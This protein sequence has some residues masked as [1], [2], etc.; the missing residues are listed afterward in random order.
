MFAQPLLD[1]APVADPRPVVARLT[2]DV[3]LVATPGF[4]SP[5]VPG[6][7]DGRPLRPPYGSVM[8]DGDSG[9]A[10][11]TAMRL[12][13]VTAALDDPI[14]LI[15]GLTQGSQR[16]LLDFLLGFCRTAFRIGA[17]P[18]FVTLCRR[19]TLLCM[20]DG[21]AAHPVARIGA[22][23]VVI[24]GM[25]APVDATLYL[26]GR[27]EVVH[28]AERGGCPQVFEPVEQEDLVLA[29]GADPAFW[30]IGPM[31]AFL[32]HALAHAGSDAE[33]RQA[34]LRAWPIGGD[35]DTRTGLVRELQLVMPAAARR[36][37]DPSQ[38]IGGALDL[39]V[40]DYDGRMFLRGWLRD[41]HDLIAG[42]ELETPSGRAPIPVA[43]FHRLRRAD[44]GAG[45]VALVDAPPYAQPTLR[46]LLRS[47]A[48][49]E[50]VPPPA[51]LAPAAARDAVLASVSEGD[52]T[53]D[54]LRRCVGPAAASL[55]RAAL[56]RLAAPDVITIGAKLRRPRI[57]LLIPLYRMLGFV[58]FQLGAF[59]SDPGFAEVE[60]IYTLD[61]PE[62]RA[63]VEHLLRGLYLL[64]ARSVTLVVMA[65]NAGFAAASN[66]AARVAR[67]PI[68]MLLN[69]DVV[70][71]APGWLEPLLA[72]LGRGCKR[73]AAPKLLFDDGS[74]QHAGLLFDRD[75]TGL[76]YNRHYH[77]GRPGDWPAANQAR[78]VPG[79]TGAALMIARAHFE[80]LGGVCEDYIVGDYEDS[81]FCLRFRALGGAVHYE[82]K[83]VLYHFERR[84]IRLHQ[85]YTR[86]L[87]SQYNRALQHGRF[88]G[89]ITA[90]MGRS[91]FLERQNSK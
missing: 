37:D 51:W 5:H 9:G 73:I 47:G 75:D 33:F 24:A 65:A 17:D 8:L 90:L 3:T 35:C 83:S 41:P 12:S 32:P 36:H 34:C 49:I 59:A 87:A 78:Q 39:A 84:S 16:R 91:M 13:A 23:R 54:L 64:H 29:T 68:V 60:I 14:V 70:P 11:I 85:G 56:S 50:L 74:L 6:W 27:R 69:S 10:R 46:L 71:A 76:W 26:L 25:Q 7:Y 4:A 15:E 44:P 81:D 63:E 79:A 19:L 61:S 18:G 82:P 2:Q 72:T 30:T 89:Q 31:P 77:K 38:A 57:A 58:R 52:A 55:H 67:A 80:R 48:G 40:P 42:A 88:D 20:R 28:S 43:G 62:Q 86:T 45:F 53:P 22:D 66:A 1:R 21:G